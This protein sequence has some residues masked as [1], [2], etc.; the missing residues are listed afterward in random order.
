MKELEGNFPT[1]LG[2][3]RDEDASCKRN[4][5]SFVYEFSLKDSTE[6]LGIPRR[7]KISFQNKVPRN[8]IS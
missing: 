1:S 3:G 8:Y 4:A 6:I 2:N 7:L 5:R